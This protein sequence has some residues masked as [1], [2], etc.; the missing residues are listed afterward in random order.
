MGTLLTIPA[1]PKI[2]SGVLSGLI[3]SGTATQP[4]PAGGDLA[5]KGAVPPE[6]LSRDPAVQKAYTDDPL[7]WDTVPPEVLGHAMTI[8]ALVADAVPL[9]EMPVLLIH[10]VDDP[11]TSIAGAEQVHAELVVT[12]KTL[13]GYKGLLHEILNEPEKDRVIADVIEWLDKH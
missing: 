8:G 4:G 5:T 1:V 7:V 9:I 13:I 2:P 3:L 12:D 10:G 11:L 6:T